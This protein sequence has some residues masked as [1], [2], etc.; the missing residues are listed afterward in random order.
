MIEISLE[1][2]LEPLF[3]TL[4]PN[5]EVQLFDQLKPGED[6]AYSIVGSDVGGNDVSHKFNTKHCISVTQRDMSSGRPV[7]NTRSEQQRLL[8]AAKR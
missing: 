7:D 3:I 1:H 4:D 8:D 6:K 5:S 2:S